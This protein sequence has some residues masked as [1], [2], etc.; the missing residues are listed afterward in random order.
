MNSASTAK[1]NAEYRRGSVLGLTVAEI[2]ILLLF[3]LLLV[4]LALTHD[5][6]DRKEAMAGELDKASQ[7]LAVANEKL[8]EWR[9]VVEEFQSPEEVQTLISKTTEAERR[10]E[11]YLQQ[12][13]VFQDTLNKSK[14]EVHKEVINLRGQISNL[15]QAA[16]DAQQ[17]FEQ[18]KQELR[19]VREKGHNPPCWYETIPDGKGGMREKPHYTFH[20]AV[21]D[22]TIIVRQ[23]PVPSGSAVDD[24]GSLYSVEAVQLGL[25]DIPYEMPLSN[26]SLIEHL[27]PIHDAGKSATVRSY[28]CIFWVRVWD[29][30]SPDAKARW[31]DAHDRVL[32]GLFGAYTVENDPWMQPPLNRPGNSGDPLV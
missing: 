32:E 23:A 4:L 16:Q 27:Q 3:L 18:V 24:N 7:Q 22:E 19:V 29:K 6:A 1:I 9:N 26:E 21:F 31:K 2:F 14:S 8:H 20:I 10:A 12:L 13:T 25:A 5:W 28:S 15:R 17:K 11:Q 30:T